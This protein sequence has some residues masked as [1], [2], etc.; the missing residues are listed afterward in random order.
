MTN[1]FTHEGW[2]IRQP[3]DYFVQVEMRDAVF[4]IS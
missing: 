4:S 2:A 3:L 1:R